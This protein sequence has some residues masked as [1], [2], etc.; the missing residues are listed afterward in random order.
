M[1]YLTATLP[2]TILVGTMLFSHQHTSGERA[3]HGR[4]EVLSAGGA[5]SVPVPHHA[6]E[7]RRGNEEQL[8]P[9]HGGG[10]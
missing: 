8:G 3:D 6:K 4:E 5:S 10:A 1:G 9:R 7:W 2:P